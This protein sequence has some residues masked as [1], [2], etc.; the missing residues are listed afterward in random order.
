MTLRMSMEV[1]KTNLIV[2]F[3]VIILVACKQRTDTDKRDVSDLCVTRN[4]LQNCFQTICLDSSGFYYFMSCD[5]NK[6]VDLSA[7]K[8]EMNIFK[9]FDTTY[10]LSLGHCFDDTTCAVSKDAFSV[11]INQNN[12]NYYYQLGSWAVC[13]TS[14]CFYKMQLVRDFFI[15]IQKKYIPNKS[16]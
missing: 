16:L 14:S 6:R 5:S 7:Y 1:I 11:F 10:F 9:S 3:F 8:K 15:H 12:K 2:N 4:T 13:D